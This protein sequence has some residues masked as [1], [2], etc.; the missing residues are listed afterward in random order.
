MT[1]P[2]KT[3]VS[4]ADTPYYH[5]VSR[6]VRRAYL[7]GYDPLT[8][9]S[10]EHRRSWL[11]IKLLKTAEI[12]AVKLCSYAVMSN[13]YHVVLHIR[14]DI[15]QSLTELE[16]VKRWHQCF[17]GTLLSQRFINGEPL[18]ENQWKALRKEIKCW[19]SR[20]SDISWY[21]RIVN[22]AIARQANKED[23]CTGRFWEGRFKS[24]ALLDDQA[25]LSCMAYV[26][27]N[28][29]RARMAATLEDS[30]HTSIRR[31]I[32]QLNNPNVN[33]DSLE[34][35]VGITENDIGIPFKLKDYLELVDWTGR[36]IRDD[37]RGHIDQAQ[38]K[39][40]SRLDLNVDA[41]KVLTTEFESQFQCW[42][43]SEHIV[44]RVCEGRGYKRKP[45]TRRHEL[46]F[47]SP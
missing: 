32:Q 18:S 45:S 42:V 10:Y 8:A 41:W 26:D 25:L 46:L 23:K 29:I 31:R 6:C 39:I 24:Q 1:L 40:L 12:F 37:K 22:E 17:N 5:C 2:R 34:A 36:V 19:R 21:M 11:E 43:G 20:L 7:C 47:N 13:H 16:V 38:P 44:R 30:H 35:F 15:A 4:L 14:P 9:K 33:D 28:P 3:L 27:L